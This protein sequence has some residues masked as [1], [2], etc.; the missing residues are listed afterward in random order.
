[1]LLGGDWNRNKILNHCL[2]NL[3]E[4][5]KRFANKDGLPI[6]PPSDWAILNDVYTKDE[7][8]EGLARYI[9]TH[10]PKFPFRE[11]TE[12]DASVRFKRFCND[13]MDSYVI[14]PNRLDSRDIVEKYKDYKHPFD[15]TGL[16]MIQFGHYYNDIS[17]FFQQENRYKCGSYGFPAPLEIWNDESLLKKMN[18]TF[19]RFENNGINMMNWRGSFR[20]GAY[21]ATQF[22]PHVAKSIYIMCRA[23]T[24]LD[25][26]CGWGD[27]LAGFYGSSAEEY[28]GCDPAD[29]VYET[30]KKQCVWYEQQLGSSPV[31]KEYTDRFVCVGKKRVEILR[32]P[33]EDINWKKYATKGIDCVFTSPPYFST[34]IYNK[35]GEHENDQSWARYDEYSKWREGFYFPML[36]SAW[37]V[38]NPNGYLM[39]NI[40]DPTIKGKRYRA[41]DDMVEM[42]T[43]KH[44]AHF[45]GQI[46]MRIK[47][48][49]KKM[50]AS[51]NE[52]LT[53]DFVENIWCFSKK[54]D[55]P[56]DFPGN[57]AILKFQDGDEK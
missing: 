25:T 44:S 3:V 11:I 12:M 13:D 48:R 53:K 54:K 2:L 10:K 36:K 43:T 38:V 50:G 24:V 20:L 23:K 52:F 27:R 1:M 9:V 32:S 40:M 16:A 34:E 46:G 6:I 28:Y 22:K 49:P 30:Y 26:S 8:R 29:D 5:I 45:M 19:W 47:Q 56:L 42:L 57:Y 4:D 21:V 14:P 51:L 17:N 55:N 15:K 18:F 7:I 35:G 31:L 33:A 37:E 39:I 41:C